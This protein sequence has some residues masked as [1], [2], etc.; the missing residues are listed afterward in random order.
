MIGPLKTLFDVQRRRAEE[1]GDLVGRLDPSRTVLLEDLITD[2]KRPERLALLG[3][4][5]LDVPQFAARVAAACI[6]LDGVACA[7]GVRGWEGLPLVFFQGGSEDEDAEEHLRR[8]EVEPFAERFRHLPP[9]VLYLHVHTNVFDRLEG[10]WE[11]RRLTIGKLSSV[12]SSY[13]RPFV[14]DGAFEAHA[15][16]GFSIGYR[17]TDFP[18]ILDVSPLVATDYLARIVVH[19]LCHYYLPT[20]P[21][22]AEGFHNA[23]SLAAMGELPPIAYRDAWEALIHRESVDPAFC[24]QARESIEAAVRSVGVPSLVQ[25]DI[26]AGFRRW[27]L[28]ARASQKRARWGLPSHAAQ[29]AQTLRQ[30]IEEARADGFRLYVRLMNDT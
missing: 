25:E 20:T 10:S 24:L 9:G 18:G 26:L 12:Y 23:A 15:V 7:D 21:N 1:D 14:Y 5:W 4:P 16:Q 30:R 6:W 2:V 11:G 19:D 17:M 8:C 3:A 13:R 27:Y 22:A 28:S 29:A